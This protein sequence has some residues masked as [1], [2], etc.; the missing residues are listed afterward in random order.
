MKPRLDI[1]VPVN[2]IFHLIGDEARIDY[3]VKTPN[4]T[5]KIR[6]EQLSLSATEKGAIRSAFEQEP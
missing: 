4:G 2:L 3:H 6:S 5:V 1:S